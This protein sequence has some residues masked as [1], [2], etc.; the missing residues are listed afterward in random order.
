MKSETWQSVFQ[1]IDVNDVLELLGSQVNLP[2]FKDET[3]KKKIYDHNDPA[4]TSKENILMKRGPLK[5]I[6]QLNN[7]LKLPF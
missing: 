1:V 7:F 5:L 4:G 3:R 6:E 2:T